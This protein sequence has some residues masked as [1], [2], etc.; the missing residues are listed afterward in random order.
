M[1][2]ARYLGLNGSLF[3]LKVLGL[4]F[5]TILLQVS[6][7]LPSG[8][9]RVLAAKSSLLCVDHYAHCSLL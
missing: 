5:M 9:G 3:E 6:N 7:T 8:T 4:Q 1:L 2:Y